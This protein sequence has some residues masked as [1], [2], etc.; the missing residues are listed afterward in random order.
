MKEIRQD[1]TREKCEKNPQLEEAYIKD[2]VE[3]S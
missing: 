2:F 1:L 3:Q